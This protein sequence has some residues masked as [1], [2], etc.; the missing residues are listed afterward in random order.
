[1]MKTTVT[2]ITGVLAIV[3]CSAALSGTTSVTTNVERVYA[4]PSD[5]WGGCMVRTESSY[6]KVNCNQNWL[7]LDCEGAVDGNTKSAGQRRFDVATLA[8][9]TG[10]RAKFRINDEIKING[11]CYADRVELIA[12]P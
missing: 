1:M 12:S 5:K 6:N 3:M 4:T 10:Q 11:Y 8:L 7:T 2:A 9:L